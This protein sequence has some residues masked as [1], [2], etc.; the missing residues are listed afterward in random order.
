MLC[1]ELNQNSNIQK[2]FKLALNLAVDVLKM[3]TSDKIDKSRLFFDLLDIENIFYSNTRNILEAILCFSY[4]END[5][6]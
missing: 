1:K 3:F 6:V 4:K 2:Y 5:D